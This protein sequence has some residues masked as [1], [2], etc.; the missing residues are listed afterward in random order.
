MTFAFSSTCF[1]WHK[2]TACTLT[3]LQRLLEKTR[4]K[5]VGGNRVYK[6]E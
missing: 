4:A 3:L 1:G 5:G 6:L 2:T